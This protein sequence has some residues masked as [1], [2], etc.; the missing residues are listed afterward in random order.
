MAGGDRAEVV[1]AV[2]LFR[3]LTYFSQIPIGG[4]TYLIWRHHGDWRRWVWDAV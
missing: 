3:F 1:A 4:I 2:L